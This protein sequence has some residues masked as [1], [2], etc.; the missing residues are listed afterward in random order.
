[1]NNFS[2]GFSRKLG[3]VKFQEALERT[4]AALKEEGFGVLTSILQLTF[5][6]DSHVFIYVLP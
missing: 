3:T 6:A 4:K 2:Y 1:M 5:Y